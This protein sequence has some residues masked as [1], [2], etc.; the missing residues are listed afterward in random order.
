MAQATEYSANLSYQ[1]GQQQLA[2]SQAEYQQMWPYVQ[3]SM[4]TQQAA[5][6]QQMAQSQAYFNNWNN[7]APA[8]QQQVAT[9]NS[10]AYDKS[11]Q[12]LSAIQN[13]QYLKTMAGSDAQVYAQNASGI[14]PMVDN[15][16]ATARGLTT[17][18]MEQAVRSGL[19]YGLSAD[20]NL[21][22][23]G[24]LG[25]GAASNEVAAGNQALQTGITNARNEA[26]TGYNAQVQQ[27]GLDQQ[28]TQQQILNNLNLVNT[29]SGL[30][31]A[32]TSAT[33]AAT[34]AG[35][36][37]VTQGNQT[38]S[39]YNT[40]TNQGNTTAMQ[41]AQQQIT[42]L[43]DILNSQ[44]NYANTVAQVDSAN[45]AGFASLGG[46]AIGAAVVL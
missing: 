1:L 45:T 3:Q 32:S 4:Q 39:V 43:G 19:R 18:N 7:N 8:L 30:P 36:A 9:E 37:G 2:Q 13:S 28:A 17:N 31:S 24:S 29:Y 14:N 11:M 35:S 33:N 12:Q 25:L 27:Y 10:Q 38:N 23:A 41:G 46:A 26:T 20:A 22:N 21:M 40:G 34:N 6:Q 44:A 5:Q 16:V 42:G 15:A